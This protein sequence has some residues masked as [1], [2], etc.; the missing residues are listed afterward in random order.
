MIT[1]SDREML[2][3]PET[4]EILYERGYS[5]CTETIPGVREEPGSAAY[6]KSERIVNMKWGQGVYGVFRK[7]GSRDKN[8]FYEIFVEK[9]DRSA[10][11]SFLLDHKKNKILHRF[12]TGFPNPAADVL[13]HV[14]LWDEYQQ[15][16]KMIEAEEAEE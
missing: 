4:G 10:L 5:F 11:V 15:Y 3:D 9:S 16:L 1:T 6:L 14:G 13:F 7:Y 8:R 12:K 2:I